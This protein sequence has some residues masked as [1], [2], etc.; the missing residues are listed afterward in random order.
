MRVGHRENVPQYLRTQHHD[1]LGQA[2]EG[3]NSIDAEALDSIR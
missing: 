1:D 3:I 2:L